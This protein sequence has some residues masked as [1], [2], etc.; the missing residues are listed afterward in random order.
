MVHDFIVDDGYETYLYSHVPSV[1]EQTFRMLTD[2][3]ESSWGYYFNKNDDL[4]DVGQVELG[5][6]GLQWGKF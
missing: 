1:E 2:D 3:F 5:K 6:T 4:T